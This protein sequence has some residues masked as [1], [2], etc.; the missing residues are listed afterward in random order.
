M[1]A[2]AQRRNRRVATALLGLLSLAGCGITPAPRYGSGVD[3][4]APE[5]VSSELT[6]RQRAFRTGDNRRLLKVVKGYLE[7]PYLWGGTTRA[8]M[9]C[10]G[11]TRAVYREAYGLEL[12]RTSKQMYALGRPVSRSSG[13]K[14]GDLVFFRISDSGPGVSHV[15]IYVGDDRFAHA[16]SSR[17]GVIDE[18]S[19]TYFTQRYVGARRILP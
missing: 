6:T 9:D 10:S 18:L 13:L 8:G 7:V 16:S 2:R 14:P 17:G 4:S 5:P 11:L 15:G 3:S 1:S 12:P 19:Q